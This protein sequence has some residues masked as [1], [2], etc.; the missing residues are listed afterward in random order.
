VC[1]NGGFPRL[2]PTISPLWPNSMVAAFRK[3][4]PGILHALMVPCAP[5]D[6]G[7][8]AAWAGSDALEAF[9]WVQLKGTTGIALRIDRLLGKRNIIAE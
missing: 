5:G 8:R 1:A 6:A 3:E 2:P 7:R 9:M 4:R